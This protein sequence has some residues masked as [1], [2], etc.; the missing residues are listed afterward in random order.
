[1]RTKKITET[2]NRTKTVLLIPRRLRN[3]L[4]GTTCTA[5]LLLFPGV[6]Y[7]SPFLYGISMVGLVAGFI[8]T[9]RVVP[10][11]DYPEES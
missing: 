9:E 2:V 7:D 6:V 3:W 4:M 8:L 10:I 11:E 5:M 1:M